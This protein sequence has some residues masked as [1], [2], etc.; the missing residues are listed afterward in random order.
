M[1]ENTDLQPAPPHA[2]GLPA[3][4][5]ATKAEA[6]DLA[7]LIAR[8]FANLHPSLAL[9]D[10]P[11]Y[12]IPVLGHY[13]LII[14]KHAIAH[15]HVDFLEDHSGVAVWLHHTEF[16][17]EP[18]NY[19]RRRAAACGPWTDNF[20]QLDALL[21]RHHPEPPYHH[22]AFL[23]V[24]EEKQGTGRGTLLLKHH[25]AILDAAG[26]P[27]YLEAAS[28]P[29]T[30]LYQR[31]GYHRGTPFHLP[32]NGPAFWPMLRQPRPGRPTAPRSPA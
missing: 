9:V 27:A 8:S 31:H 23:A 17:P 4:L 12:R 11:G 13:F 21:D 6:R 25:H 19:G 5:R 18:K 7:W 20:I 15:G 2:S 32:D 1:I 22:L 3:V 14:V 16:V 24:D 10:D 29:L 30:L 26:T 28:W